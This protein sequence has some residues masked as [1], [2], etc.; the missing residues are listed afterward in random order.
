MNKSLCRQLPVFYDKSGRDHSSTNKLQRK[1]SSASATQSIATN[2]TTPSANADDE[3]QASS[4]S[5]NEVEDDLRE[6]MEEN[7]VSPSF[8]S[9]FYD[10]EAAKNIP[11]WVEPISESTIQMFGAFNPAVDEDV[12]VPLGA[13]DGVLPG[14]LKHECDHLRNTVEMVYK[15]LEIADG[16]S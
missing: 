10:I 13:I 16:N 11:I 9:V 14:W 5:Q 8:H 7:E 3:T 2:A 6:I 15:T 1:P 4:S 12:I